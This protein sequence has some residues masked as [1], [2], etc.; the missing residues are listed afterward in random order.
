MPRRCRFDPATLL[1]KPGSAAGHCLTQ[2]Q[3]DAA[4]RIYQGV[5]KSDGT[6]LFQGFARGSELKWPQMWASKTPG[7]SS[8]DFWRYSVFQDPQFQQHRF[9]L[10]PRRRSRPFHGAGRHDAS[11]TSTM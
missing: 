9:R 4:N 3:I 6:A 2:V 11:P 8:W 7:G 5:H 10:R 1:C